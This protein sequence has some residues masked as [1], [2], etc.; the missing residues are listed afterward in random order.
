[1]SWILGR[2]STQEINN[3]ALLE[4]PVSAPGSNLIGNGNIGLGSGAFLGGFDPN[5]FNF[6]LGTG[7]S[8]PPRNFTLR[9]FPASE[10]QRDHSRMINHISWLYGGRVNVNGTSK[11]VRQLLYENHRP[12][13]YMA[14]RLRFLP[15]TYKAL[16]DNETPALPPGSEFARQRSNRYRVRF[17]Y[18]APRSLGSQSVTKIFNLQRH[19]PDA[20]PLDGPF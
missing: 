9:Y 14:E 7:S 13:F 15:W 6:S 5:N 16:I 2:L 8:G 17:L 19:V 4:T 10:F 3:A 1:K 20:N 18:R 11:T 12:E